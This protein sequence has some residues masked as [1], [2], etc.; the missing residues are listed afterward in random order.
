MTKDSINK[1]KDRSQTR[2]KCKNKIHNK[3]NIHNTRL[4]NNY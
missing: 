4:P 2:R 3:D 1:I